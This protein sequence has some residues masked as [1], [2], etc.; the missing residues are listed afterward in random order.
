MLQWFCLGWILGVACMGKMWLDWHAGAWAAVCA[1]L[2]CLA[3]EKMLQPYLQR[4]SIFIHLIPISL[5]VLLGAGLGSGYAGS[6]LDQRLAHTVREPA[7]RELIVYIQRLN[8]LGENGIQQKITVLNHPAGGQQDADLQYLAYLPKAKAAAEQQN[9]A[10]GRY[11]RLQ[12]ELKPAHSYATAGAFDQEKWHLQQNIASGFR[13]QRIEPLTAQQLYAMGY[14]QQLK[15]HQRLMP[16][17]ALKVEQQRLNFREFI[18]HQPLKHQGLLLA[19]LT[20]DESLLSRETKAQ[21][22]RFG[23][24]HLLAISGPHVLVFAMMLCWLL[25]RMIARCWPQLY[26]TVPRP[27]L[28][29]WPFLSCAALY[30]AF[31]GFEI[32]ALRTLLMCS[33]GSL[34]L[35]MQQR[36]QPLKLLIYSAS[37]LLLI[38]PFSIL[39]AAFWLS[40]GACFILLRIYQTLQ[41]QKHQLS[42]EH[43]WKRRALISFKLLIESQWKIF[44]AL[45]PLM[46]LFFKQVSWITP[47][48][49]IAAIP[50]LGLI[51]VPLDLTAALSYYFSEALSALLFQLNDL[52]LSLLLAFLDLLDQLFAPELHPVAMNA[53]MLAALA[54]SLLILF[55]PRGLAPKGWAVLGVLA[56]LL[57]GS[58]PY[59]F[60]LTVLDVGQGQA[61]FIREQQRSLMVDMGGNYDEEKFSVG[62]QIIQPFLSVNALSELDQLVLTHLDQ[63][64]SGGYFSIQHQLP[65]RQLYSSEK[66]NAPAPSQF[67]YCRQ[68]QRWQWS[69]SVSIEVLSPKPAQLRTASANKN[70][71][72]CVL[73]VQ[74][75]D[76]Y[77]Y[78]NFLLMGDAGWPTEFQLLQDYPD[79]KVDVLVL[80]HHGSR[81]SSAYA[82]LKALQPKLA[83][84]SAGK[85]NRYGHP[86][87]LTQ[88]RLAQ[89][90]IPLLSTPQQGSI[91]FQQ[92]GH[93]MRLRYA[94]DGWKWLRRNQPEDSGRAIS[95]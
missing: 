79:L 78:R 81:H 25:Q 71:S 52:C 39:S 35:L 44:L 18:Q 49:N 87:A 27:Y 50:W 65:I 92:Q 42:R 7:Q 55:M 47:F 62:R 31:A 54:L 72:S 32:P 45:F 43:D 14:A 75:Q 11:Y 80:G 73:Y 86:S 93:Q 40:Y 57:Q 74:V 23:I 20:G 67:D 56:L 10:L 15:R 77:P 76:A 53:Y 5:S 41:Q 37:V 63:D 13:V 8:E 84:A 1:V 46:A 94:R 59:P 26:L 61:V 38:D 51:A 19:L 85:F 3:A 33:L 58:M 64:H 90:H 6:R 9:L 4:A 17:L 68:G 28:L 30:C 89:L 24:S 21:F 48:S 29:V 22:Q 95:D 82:F 88:A 69:K 2:I 12:G 91:Q 70:E 16:Q 36:L 34:I 66:V 83:I 60:E